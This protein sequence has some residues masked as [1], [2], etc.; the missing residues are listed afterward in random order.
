MSVRSERRNSL[1]YEEKKILNLNSMFHRRVSNYFEI[2][3]TKLLENINV[4]ELLFC[5]FH[6]NIIF[7]RCDQ[8]ERIDF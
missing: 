6:Q 3:K 7:S 5:K 2:K 8:F 4:E 1:S